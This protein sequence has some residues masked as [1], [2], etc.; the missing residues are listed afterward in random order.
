M[1][2]VNLPGLDH[3]AT[4]KLLQHEG[5]HVLIILWLDV[6]QIA[7]DGLE[8]EAEEVCPDLLEAVHGQGGVAAVVE[9]L[10]VTGASLLVMG[11]SLTPEPAPVTRGGAHRVQD[12]WLGNL[13]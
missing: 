3:L 5:R 4:D 8:G 1:I 9:E 2:N 12:Y 7:L 13:K 11:H 6:G 10:D